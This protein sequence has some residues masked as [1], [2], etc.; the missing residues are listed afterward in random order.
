MKKVIQL[1]VIC[2]IDDGMEEEIGEYLANESYNCLWNGPDVYD[3]KYN[4]F[5]NF[6]ED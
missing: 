3:I 5:Y 6:E 4:G 2:D 1:D